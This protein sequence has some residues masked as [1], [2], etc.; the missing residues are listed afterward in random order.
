MDILVVKS[1]FIFAANGLFEKL[2]EM[3]EHI[4]RNWICTLHVIEENSLWRG[5]ANHIK[6]RFLVKKSNYCSYELEN[7]TNFLF[8]RQQC[9]LMVTHLPNQQT[10]EAIEMVIGR[11]LDIIQAWKATDQIIKRTCKRIMPCAKKAEKVEEVIF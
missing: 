10:M 6:N 4:K 8:C 1:F 5:N 3:P 11:I 7:I 2:V 9:P